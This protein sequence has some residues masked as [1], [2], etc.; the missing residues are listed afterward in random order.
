MNDIVLEHP[1]ITEA[2][3]II[4]FNL[5]I[6]K[7]RAG[8]IGSTLNFDIKSTIS[9]W[10][11][12]VRL[13]YHNAHAR[14][15]TPPDIFRSYFEL[16]LNFSDAT[17]ILSAKIQLHTLIGSFAPISISIQLLPPY[18]LGLITLGANL[19]KI[20]QHAEEIKRLAL[21]YG[22]C[23]QYR[24]LLSNN[25][26]RC[27][28]DMYAF[29][30]EMRAKPSIFLE[31]FKQS[32]PTDRASLNAMQQIPP[33]AWKD[34]IT[35]VV[36]DPRIQA[37]YPNI[38]DRIIVEGTSATSAA[39]SVPE[40]SRPTP[41]EIIRDI[42]GDIAAFAGLAGGIISAIA[43]LIATIVTIAATTAVTA[44]GVGFLV[45]AIV[46]MVFGLILLGVA[47][48][49]FIVFLIIKYI[50]TFSGSTEEILTQTEEYLNS[51]Y[52]FNLQPKTLP[53]F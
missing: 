8:V 34:A 22:S 18:I 52:Q 47:L 1:G 44:T 5:L 39:A 2:D 12:N 3:Q 38:Q 35:R 20:L 6:L 27:N 53:A 7:I 51:L 29:Q 11:Q 48:F 50:I 33:E 23:L 14:L 45:V 15:T 19:G 13:S 32:M 43:G 9:P 26:N 49:F 40:T 21:N 10:E 31:A 25:A 46:L 41:V 24:D 4:E 16:N 30:E 36:K 42:L 17:G 28:V 37:L